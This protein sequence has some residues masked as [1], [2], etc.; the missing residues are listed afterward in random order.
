MIDRQDVMNINFL[1]KSRFTGSCEGMHY[2]LHKKEVEDTSKLEA[3]IWPGPFIYDKTPDEKKERKLF[4]FTK[5]GV[6][7]AVEWM[8]E[9]FVQQSARWEEEKNYFLTHF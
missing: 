2:L 4:E 3:V 6:D 8:N 1:K 5:E 7:M 9:Q